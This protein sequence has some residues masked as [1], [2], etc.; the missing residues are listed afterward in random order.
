MDLVL[1]IDEALV[2]HCDKCFKDRAHRHDALS[3]RYLAFLALEIGK[4]LHVQVK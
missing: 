4:I 3:H 2:P 1:Q